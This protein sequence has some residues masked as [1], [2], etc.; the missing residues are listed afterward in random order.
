MSRK[1]PL[2]YP[3]PAQTKFRTRVTEKVPSDY[4]SA[5]FKS[6]FMGGPLKKV[7]AHPTLPIIIGIATA[8][9]GHSQMLV[10]SLAIMLCATCLALDVGVWISKKGWR[11]QHKEIIFCVTSCLLCC[12][13]MGAMYWFLNSTL[14]DQQKDVWANL[15]VQA[16]SSAP[17]DDPFSSIFTIT[18]GGQ[19]DIGW[20]KITCTANTVYFLGGL[21]YTG[22]PTTNHITE[23]RTPLRSGRR[24]ESVIC[25]DLFSAKN[26]LGCADITVNIDYVLEDQPTWK[27][28]KPFRFFTRREEGIFRWYEF[29]L[30]TPGSVCNTAAMED[31]GPPY[32]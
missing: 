19:E 27:Q 31:H 28:H 9:T 29:S 3:A 16:P 13:A 23:S 18:N 14:G 1:Y 8:A 20:H 21:L 11:K 6:S 30:D 24:S 10:R 17:R 15:V 25:L 7:S 22:L 2:S 32:K 4:L 5:V 12:S 26:R